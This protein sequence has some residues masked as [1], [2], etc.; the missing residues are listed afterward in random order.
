MTAG[1]EW[2]RN[3]KEGQEKMDV[4]LMYGHLTDASWQRRD[5][6]REGVVQGSARL[7]SGRAT[8][9]WH[10]HEKQEYRTGR[11]KQEHRRQS[12]LKGFK[13]CGI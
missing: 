8:E 4:Q 11:E 7:A 1:D 10:C 13:I 9:K 12:K 5:G 2:R 6:L 3:I